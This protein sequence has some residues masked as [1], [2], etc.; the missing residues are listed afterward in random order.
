[1]FE[2]A[3]KR[4]PECT[5]AFI[6]DLLDARVAASDHHVYVYTYRKIQIC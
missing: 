4:F 2:K 1:M 3:S 5:N 6:S